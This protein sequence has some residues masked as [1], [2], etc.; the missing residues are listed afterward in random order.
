MNKF[1]FI[2]ME[3]PKHKVESSLTDNARARIGT[4]ALTGIGRESY[5][6]LFSG[7]GKKFADKRNV[8]GISSGAVHEPKQNKGAFEDVFCVSRSKQTQV[9]N[10]LN[11]VYAGTAHDGSR[12]EDFGKARNNEIMIGYNN[13][14][15]PTEDF[16]TGLTW[17][18]DEGNVLPS[19]LAN[20]SSQLLQ[21]SGYY[22]TFDLMS[23]KVEG[24]PF[25]ISGK[26]HSVSGF[27]G[28]RSDSIEHVEY[29]FLTAQPSSHSGDSKVSSFDS[30]MVL[31]FD[32]SDWLGKE[33][34]PLLP[35]VAG[36]HQVPT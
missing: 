19:G 36:R 2:A 10:N 21:S 6:S 26:C 27:E 11:M 8:P 13:H 16:L 20:S 28:L 30:E 5:S 9:G 35:K 24:E 33:A 3:E 15:R 31:K 22:P 1:S 7:K 25:N 32:S 17:K 29:N 34:L 12:L 23:H 18:S 14:A 4:F